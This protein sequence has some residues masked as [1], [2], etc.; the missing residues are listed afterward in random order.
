MIKYRL[1]SVAQ[2]NLGGGLQGP[3]LNEPYFHDIG[4]LIVTLYL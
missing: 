4:A 1:S 2:S 3:E